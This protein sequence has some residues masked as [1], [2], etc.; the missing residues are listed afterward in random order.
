MK[1]GYNIDPALLKNIG[2]I[3]RS[4]NDSLKPFIEQYN[5]AFLKISPDVSERLNAIL[6]ENISEPDRRAAELYNSL[7]PKVPTEQLK[8]LSASLSDGWRAAV[9]SLEPA[10]KNLS[11]KMKDIYDVQDTT[12]ETAEILKN[13]VINAIDALP[14]SDEQKAEI[15]DSEPMLPLKNKD[16]LAKADIIAAA[17]L[18]VQIIQLLHEIFFK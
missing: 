5:E 2:E 6:R 10:L 15:F 17:A 7:E 14:I 18:L 11:E 13:E 4:L 12:D 16:K 1:N 9:E 3:S 8:E